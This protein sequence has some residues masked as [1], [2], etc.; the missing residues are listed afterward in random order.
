MQVFNRNVSVRGLTVFGFEIVLI[1]GSMALAASVHGGFSA[2][3]PAMLSK[4]VVVT[5]LCQLCFYY[6]DLY[7]LT[8]VHSNRE[9][10]VR[11]LQAAGAAA[12]VLAF[13]RIAFPTL[14]LDAG[15]IE[16]TLEFDGGGVEGTRLAQALNR[17]ERTRAITA[18]L[19]ERSR[20]HKDRLL[21]APDV[22]S[23][24][25]DRAHLADSV[26]REAQRVRAEL[27]HDS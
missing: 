25:S 26:G 11:L 14:T 12:I 15:V 23:F 16:R 18:R 8:I 24:H 19:V 17:R 20:E 10:V 9:L 4:I 21:G 22:G 6:N 1:S 7:D 2:G 13:A 27:I 3:S 5:A